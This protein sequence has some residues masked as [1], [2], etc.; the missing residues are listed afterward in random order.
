MSTAGP[1]SEVDPRVFVE[2]LGPALRQAAAV[3]RALEGRVPNRPKE[4]A[5]SDVKAALTLAD[6]AAQE[7]LLSA[8]QERFPQ[9]AL[10]AEEDTPGVAAF[11]A[12]E[13]GRPL[14]VI[15]PIDGTLHSYLEH[16]G[17]YAVMVGL[18]VTGR[19]QAALVALPREGLFFDG[20]RGGP[21]RRT[22]PRGE[23]RPVRAAADGNAVLVS[24][25]MPGRVRERILE[26]GLAPVSGCG[27]AISVAPLIPGVGAPPARGPAPH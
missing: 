26:R 15:D 19:Y 18:A 12:E 27:G 17:P 16:R 22:R 25:E 20:V 8:L 21:A 24:H 4:G 5:D 9:V 14:V 2:V 1:A 6:S 23:A 10:R 3:A 13:P 7:A 11:P